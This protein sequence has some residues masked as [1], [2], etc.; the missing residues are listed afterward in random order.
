M[1]SEMINFISLGIERILKKETVIA[2]QIYGK[3]KYENLL[4]EKY[5]VDV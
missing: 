1:I 3:K 5:K 4:V 2:F